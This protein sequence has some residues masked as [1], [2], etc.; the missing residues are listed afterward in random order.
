MKKYD[1]LKG[2]GERV[3][4]LRRDANLTQGELALQLE[5]VGS[6]VGK[7]EKLPDSFPSIPVLLKLSELFNVSTDYL[8][9]GVEN[10]PDIDDKINGTNNSLIQT[11]TQLLSPETE[12]LS[13][14][15]MKLNVRDRVKLLNYA[16]QLEEGMAKQIE[17]GL[18]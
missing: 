8:L 4:K 7:Y 14:I 9:K 10:V 6:A 1:C 16:M 15:Y 3:R 17:G 18:S 12:E 5:V 11:N 13:K 2:F